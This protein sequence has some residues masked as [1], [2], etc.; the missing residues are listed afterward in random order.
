MS[1][2]DSAPTPMVFASGADSLLL[3]PVVIIPSDEAGPPAES[4]AVAGLADLLAAIAEKA[5][6][7]VDGAGADGAGAEPVLAPQ[8]LSEAALG[9]A[10]DALDTALARLDGSLR[11]GG[12]PWVEAPDAI[13]DTLFDWSLPDGAELRDRLA[14][15]IEDAQDRFAP[16]TDIAPVAQPAAAEFT[17]DGQV[18]VV[19]DDGWSP[20]YDQTAQISDFD[21]AGLFND[22]WARVNRIDSHGSWVAETVTNTASAV[23]IVHLKVF[24]N[25]PGAGASLFDIEEA[26]DWVI[27]NAGVLDIAAVNLSLGFGNA[28]RETTTRLSDEFAELDALGIFS[29][30]AAGNEGDRYADGVSVIAADPNVIAVSATNDAGRFAGFSQRSETLTD[31]AAPGVDVEVETLDGQVLD[32]S[33]TSFSAPMISGIAAILQEAAQEVIGERLSDEEFLEILQA[34]GE[35]V[36]GEG[37]RPPA[38]YRIADA[39]AALDYFLEN[40]SDYGDV[41]IG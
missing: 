38:G 3:D 21:F 18:V 11:D 34:S 30:V 19:I 41:L 36:S 28:T 29:V 8:S 1:R 25:F 7:A 39:D 9:L 32:V 31:I 10:R 16:G 12:A 4:S 22:P 2:H 17:G 27:D 23:E 14:S 24:P 35:A 13:G 40:A 15:R 20:Y 5:S 6:A 37:L 26:L 33:G